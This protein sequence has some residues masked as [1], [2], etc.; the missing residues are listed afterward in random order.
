MNAPCTAHAH[1][2]MKLHCFGAWIVILFLTHV[3]SAMVH[4]AEVEEPYK[5]MILRNTSQYLPAG[6]LQDRGMQEAFAVKGPGR[7]E[8]FVETMD[9]FWFDRSDIEPEFLSLF[10]K[11]YRNRK[12]DLLMV[13]GSDALDATQ[14]FHDLLLPGVPVVFFN[15]A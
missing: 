1:H 15:V 10:R 12:I 7:V 3:I 14:R 4:A 9:T 6:I 13:S 2:W 5:V 11:K 8:F